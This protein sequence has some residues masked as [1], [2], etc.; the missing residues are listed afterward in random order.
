M[1]QI[2]VNGSDVT[3][4]PGATILEAARGS[5]IDI[6]TLCWYP[7]LPIVGNCRICL[8]SVQGQGKLLPACATPATDG[9]VVETESPAA[10][11]NRRGVLGLLLERYPGTR[12]KLD[13]TS[14]WD[15]TL[16]A[17]LAETGAVDTTDLKGAYKGTPVHQPGD[18]ELYRLVAE[19]FPSAWIED[20]DLNDETDPVLAPHRDRITWDAPIHSVADITG[21]PFA[22]KT[23]NFKPSRFGSVQRLFDGYDYCEERGIAIYGGG[24]WELG[25]GRGQI[26]H[27]ASLFHPTTPNDVAPAAFNIHRLDPPPGLPTSPLDPE[28]SA[29]GFR[30]GES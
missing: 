7:K 6:P 2:T 22:P 3:F 8:V 14:E 23:L 13:P 19:G 4:E 29:T 10:V 17:A 28:P 21:L 25:P 15:D 5:G 24:Q 9:M 30:W 11:D 12:F 26:Q 16:V 18:P 1:A 20:P 27:L